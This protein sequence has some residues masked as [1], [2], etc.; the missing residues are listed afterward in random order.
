[1][2][3]SSTLLIEMIVFQSEPFWNIEYIQKLWMEDAQQFEILRNGILIEKTF[4]L[5]V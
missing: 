2:S 4:T 5:F 3:Y 1:M